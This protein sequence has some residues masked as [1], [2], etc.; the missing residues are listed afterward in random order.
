[1][2]LL[3]VTGLFRTILIIIGVIVILR[4]VGKLMQA[5]R[6][7]DE[8]NKMNKELN[9]QDKMVDEAKR[10]YGKTSLTNFKTEG[11]EGEFVDFEDVD[12]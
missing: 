9:E 5:K 3:S 10:N 12:E 6:K 11:K 2:V 4:F 1:M 8:H 7:M